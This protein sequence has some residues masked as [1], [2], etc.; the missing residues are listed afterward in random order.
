MQWGCE[1]KIEQ[2]RDECIEVGRVDVLDRHKCIG[3]LVMGG[4][5]QILITTDAEQFLMSAVHP[6]I[7]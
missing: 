2:T 1:V 5:I 4:F 7:L 6:C 3:G